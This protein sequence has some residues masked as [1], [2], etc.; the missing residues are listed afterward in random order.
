MENAGFEKYNGRVNLNADVKPWL[1]LSAQ[2]NGY[3]SNMDP[4]AKYTTSGTGV[5][6]V[7]TYTGATTPGMVF[8]APDGRYGAMNNS[9]DDAQSLS[10]TLY[11]V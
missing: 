1:S 7:F 2:V 9:E 3:L 8:R 11:P 5:D 6:D 4:A 10:I